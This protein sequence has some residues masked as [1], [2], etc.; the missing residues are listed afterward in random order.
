MSYIEPTK[1]ERRM[2]HC[3][4]NDLVNDMEHILIPKGVS[5][6]LK[7]KT[8]EKTS[9]HPSLYDAEEN[10]LVI[11]FT[12]GT[13]ISVVIESDDDYYLEEYI[14]ALSWYNPDAIGYISGDKFHYR[15]HIKQLIDV[16]VVKPIDENILKEKILENNKKEELREYAQYERLKEKYENY[17]PKEKYGIG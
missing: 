9:F 14:P 11:T 6:K 7:G 16:G 8:I 12:D 3:F 1:R 4:A 13:Y 15:K 2:E 10:H 5:D 17:N